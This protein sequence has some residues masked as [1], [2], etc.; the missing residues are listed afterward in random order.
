MTVRLRSRM[1]HGDGQ[2]HADRA[3]QFGTD[4][5]HG[6]QLDVLQQAPQVVGK[7]GDGDGVRWWWHAGG[8]K[9]AQIKTDEAIVRRQVRH[10]LEPYATMLGHAVD[11][12]ATSCDS[13]GRV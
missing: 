10:P 9:A 6:G 1:G 13:Q 12:Q 8:P 7:S 4:E 2:L 5:V 3:P 11:Q